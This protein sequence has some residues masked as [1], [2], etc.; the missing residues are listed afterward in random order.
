M[1]QPL[2]QV[3]NLTTRFNTERGRLTAVDEVSFDIAPGETVAIV[4]ESGSGKSVTALSIMRLI[5]TPP[6]RIDS[7]E[8]IFDGQDLMKLDDA[9]MRDVKSELLGKLGGNDMDDLSQRISEAVN[10]A[11][12]EAMEGAFDG[13]EDA[14]EDVDVDFEFQLGDLDAALKAAI[15]CSGGGASTCSEACKA[16]CSKT[17]QESSGKKDGPTAPAHSGKPDKHETM[18]RPAERP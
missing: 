17:C 10:D 18:A 4:G 6:G 7:G 1:A 2:L 15:E 12:S 5:P 9:A 3:R 11:I 16:S 14:L 13:L 8:V